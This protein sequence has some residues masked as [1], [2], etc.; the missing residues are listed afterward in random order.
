MFK[1][2][3]NTKQPSLRDFLH[4]NKNK[5]RLNFKYTPW[6]KENKN[7]N[8]TIT[9]QVQNKNSIGFCYKNEKKNILWQENVPKTSVK[10]TKGSGES[11]LYLYPLGT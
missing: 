2:V 10:H 3:T 5:G 9:W 7:K 11:Y 1:D 8:M 4:K 6:N